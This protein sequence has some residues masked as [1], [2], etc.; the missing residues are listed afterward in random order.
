MATK[1]WIPW[2]F[3]VFW[4][5]FIPSRMF[6]RLGHCKRS[7]MSSQ[8]ALWVA[9]DDDQG[10][11]CDAAQ[12]QLGFFALISSR[13]FYKGPNRELQDMITPPK[14]QVSCE[15]HFLSWHYPLWAI[16][17]SP[18]TEVRIE[19]FF[20]CYWSLTLNIQLWNH[21][22]SFGLISCFDHIA[23]RSFLYSPISIVNA[24]SIVASGFF[25]LEFSM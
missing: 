11:W 8:T 23:L 25:R 6:R 16:F 14:T 13:P 2:K 21:F 24:L 10:L 4:P 15:R 5:N 7:S 9:C 18:Y 17:I 12:W 20:S 1:I 22:I 3:W 19:T